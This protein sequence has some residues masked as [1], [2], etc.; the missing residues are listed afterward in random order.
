[1]PHSSLREPIKLPP[2]L[3][4]KRVMPRNAACW[5]NSGK[6]WKNCHKD[7][8]I[9]KPVTV[10]LGFAKLQQEFSKGYC[11]H[12][13]ASTTNCS[14]APIRAHTVQR[15]GGIDTIAEK[16]HVISAKTAA[17]DIYKNKG[18][19][20]PRSVGVRSASTFF[21]FC[22]LHDTQMFR[23]IEKGTIQI[24]DE[25]CF[26]MSFRAISYEHF[27]KRAALRASESLREADFGRSFEEQVFLQESL[28]AYREGLL[29]GL[30]DTTW[31]KR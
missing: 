10:G 5:C 17:Q 8:H 6:K 27:Q 25:T 13:N 2:P 20:I 18:Q 11:S 16:G 15:R 1:M 31:S 26:L 7:R 28:S 14:G 23:P 22:N 24:N 3:V 4:P 30:Q 19:F 9:K 21:G 29:R 12:P